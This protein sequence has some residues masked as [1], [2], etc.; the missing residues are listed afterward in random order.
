MAKKESKE[1]ILSGIGASPGICIGKAY[2]VGNEGVDV[3]EKYLIPKSQLEAEKKRFKTAVK[4]A[5]DELHAIIE[6]TPDDFREHADILETHVVMLKDKMLYGRTIE[7]IEK[8]RVN[9]EWA[10]RKVVKHVQS[11]FD[12]MPDPYFRERTADI[13]HVYDRIMSYLIG[14]KM[15]NVGDIDKRV[16]LVAKN[17]SPAETSQIQLEKVKGFVTDAGGMTSHTGIIARA[18]EIPAVLGLD[19]ATREINNDDIIIVDGN[20][21]LVIINP[22]EESLVRF[23]ERKSRYEAFR[24]FIKRNSH[25][26][27]ETKDGFVIRVMGNIDL[28]E[29]VVSTK[30]NGG[31]GI[32]LFRTEFQFLSHSGFPGE[33]NLFDNYKDVVEVMHPNP[34]TIRTL[35]LDGDKTVTSHDDSPQNNP[36]LGLRGIRYCLKHPNIFRAQLR[37]ILRAAVYGNVRVMFPMISSIEEIIMAK[38]ILDECAQ[39]LEKD[40][41]S[42][43]RDLKLGIMIEVPS[44]VMIA[45][46]FAEH[47]DFF[48]IGTNDLV[49]YSLA[50]DRGNRHVAHLHNPLHPAVLRMV[51]QVSN[52]AKQSGIDVYMCGEM[53]ADPFNIPILLGLGIDELSMNPQSIPVVKRM[54]R[55]IDFRDTHEFVKDVLKQTTAAKVAEMIEEQYGAFLKDHLYQQ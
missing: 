34:V 52:V 54:I 18:L 35:D 32:G 22:T 49:Q 1:I 47:V 33:Y 17:L 51:Q 36:A 15:E 37:A 20:R 28:P 50:V 8:E 40:N 10:L 29:E 4:R 9:A 5:K 53:A 3:V 26:P 27:A 7:T 11:I 24:S 44:A 39:S 55:S 31:D 14:I 42:F 16:I 21:G 2:L 38:K 46:L 19:R 25:F 23:E 12:N 6:Q 48:S 13:S 30:D 45:D 41:V 43:N